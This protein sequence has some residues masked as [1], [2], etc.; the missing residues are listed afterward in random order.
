MTKN[1]TKHGAPLVKAV[2]TFWAERIWI[3][4]FVM[5]LICLDPTFLDFP[6]IWL[7]QI[8][9]IWNSWLPKI[10]IPGFQ[11]IHTAAGGRGADGRTD[12]R[13]DGRADGRAGG[14]MDVRAGGRTDGP[15][16][17]N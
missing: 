8:P 12:G 16:S 5:F 10:W 4:R 14:R 2:H 1:G 6:N 11:K 15:L 17:I 7:S 9:K 13:T 3:L